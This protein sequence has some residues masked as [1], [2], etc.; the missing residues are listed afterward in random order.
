MQESYTQLK[1]HYQLKSDTPKSCE[2]LDS[3]STRH[4]HGFVPTGGGGVGGGWDTGCTNPSPVVDAASWRNYW[5]ILFVWG[6]TN[7]SIHLGGGGGGWPHPQRMKPLV[8]KSLIGGGGCSAANVQVFLVPA[9][10]WDLYTCFTPVWYIS[11]WLRV[12][13]VHPPPP[14]MNVLL[15]MDD[16]IW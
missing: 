10:H 11:Y 12:W 9:N 2:I 6:V 14:L 16:T 8:V 4:A 5:V 1:T 3:G 15:L 13:R 7:Y